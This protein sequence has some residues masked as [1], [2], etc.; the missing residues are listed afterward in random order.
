MPG[1]DMPVTVNFTEVVALGMPLLEIW[2][3]PL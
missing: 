1:A 2:H 3:S